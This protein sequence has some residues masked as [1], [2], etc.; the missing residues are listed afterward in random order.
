MAPPYRDNMPTTTAPET[1]PRV[2]VRT[3]YTALRRAAESHRKAL[4]RVAELDVTDA[5]VF[6]C[7]R[8]DLVMCPLPGQE[9]AAMVGLAV[10]HYAAR[11]QDG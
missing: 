8:C 7:S 10:G 3:A 9:R 11:H 2:E 5:L 4:T 6:H 1:D